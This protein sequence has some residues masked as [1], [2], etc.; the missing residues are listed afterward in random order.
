MQIKS[1]KQSRQ[2][3][4]QNQ[5]ERSR[6]KF[7]FCKVSIRDTIKYVSMIRQYLSEE[8]N[9]EPLKIICMG[10]RNGRELDL[11]RLTLNHSFLTRIIK[12]TEWHTDGFHSIF[13]R[14]FL[15]F[16][17][18]YLADIERGS[19][20][21]VE[22]NPMAERRDVYVGSFDELPQSWEGCFNVVYSNSFDHCQDPYKTAGQW[23]K[24]IKKG[25]LFV[26]AFS[27]NAQATE[28]DPI[29]M[30]CLEDIRNLFP[31]RLLYYQHNGSRNNYSEVIIKNE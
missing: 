27:D 8:V 12:F 5:T 14:F 1:I 20:F 31:G 4:F 19:V 25:G 23:R 9:K 6:K 7:S 24:I 17:R 28:T 10:T 29:G 30:I 11:F 18:S 16:S 26:I 13:D 21:G 22:I 2:Q 15:S 3:Y